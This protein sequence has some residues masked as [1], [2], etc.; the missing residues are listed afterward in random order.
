MTTGAAWNIDQ[1]APDVLK[2]WANFDADAIRDIPFDW[3]EWLA[4]IESTY[5]SHTITTH[6][7]LECTNPTTG[8][9]GGIIKARI[10]KNPAGDP[11]LTTAGKYT[12]W[13]KCHIVAADG[14]EDEQTLYLRIVAK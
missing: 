14:Q 3:T 2:P 11:L 5:A 13:V 4:D 1:E 6:A 7:D 8:E 10:Q 12:Y 9:S